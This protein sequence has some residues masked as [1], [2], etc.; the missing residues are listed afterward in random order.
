MLT[1]N[2]FRSHT[3]SRG[4]IDWPKILLDDHTRVIYNKH[5]LMLMTEPIQ[6]DD[7]Q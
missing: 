2:K 7:H 1:Y 3:L 5:L 4:T 6:W